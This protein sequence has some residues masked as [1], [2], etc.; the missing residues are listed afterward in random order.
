MELNRLFRPFKRRLLK[1]DLIRSATGALAVAS[2]L[3]F[4]ASVLY[5]FKIQEPD[6]KF[7]LLC[8]ACSFLA[9]FLFLF[10]FVFYPWKKRIARRIDGTGL[11][12]RISTMLEYRK[13]DS[14]VAYVQRR[15]ALWYLRTMSP[16]RISLRINRKR[17]LMTAVCFVLMAGMLLIPYDIFA[18]INPEIRAR[19]EL[20]QKI[21]ALSER[22]RT[23]IVDA[24]YPETVETPL[25]AAVDTLQENMLAGTNDLQR[26]TA[27]IK[28]RQEMEE[29]VG[30]FVS[31]LEIGDAFQKYPETRS[32]GVAVTVGDPQMVTDS[33]SDA[34][35][36]VTEDRD[37]A[38]SLSSDLASS[39]NA[40][41]IDRSD[42]LLSAFS[43]L[44]TFL[45][46]DLSG[47]SDEELRKE[48]KNKNYAIMDQIDI[49][50][51]VEEK[52][53]MLGKTL[54]D[55]QD[56]LLGYTRPE[57]P[58]AGVVN[59][60]TSDVVEIAEGVDLRDRDAFIQPRDYSYGMDEPMYDPELG[61]VTFGEVYEKYY[62]KYKEQ[63]KSGVIP[64]ELKSMLDSYF[65]WLNN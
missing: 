35:T 22:L 1:E 18:R 60:D 4:Y 47:L 16:K 59:T 55:I 33:L 54:Q 6:R 49:Q 51:S 17:M 29:A 15:N 36:H 23:E 30:E 7:L 43:D 38:S 34:A 37:A 9:V 61:M 12:D 48:L 39:L 11:K 10:F 26:A 28:A 5:H 19:L 46:E 62:E 44:S 14:P 21:S 52:F 64:E 65:Y 41:G 31:R 20:E 56:A 24:K 42:G 13:D 40:A 50:I 8:F 32:L 63:L 53:S 58:A 3:T 45:S 2:I 25:L 27:V 57:D